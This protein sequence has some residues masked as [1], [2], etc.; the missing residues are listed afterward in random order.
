LKRGRSTTL[1]NN[2]ITNGNGFSNIDK[3]NSVPHQNIKKENK[4]ISNGGIEKPKSP[5]KQVQIYNKKEK[6]DILRASSV[7]KINDSL[8][9]NFKFSKR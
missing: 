3:S 5:T 7:T 9:K 2:N 8:N 4:K 1:T 6:K